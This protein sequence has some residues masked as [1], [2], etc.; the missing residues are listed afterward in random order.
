M[1]YLCEGVWGIC[2]KIYHT[3]SNYALGI[4]HFNSSCSQMDDWL[5]YAAW[6][7]KE[8]R[9]CITSTLC[10]VFWTFKI[11]FHP[12]RKWA[13]HPGAP[14]TYFNDGGGGGG[15]RKFF[16]GRRFWPFIVLFLTKT[17]VEVGMFYL[18]RRWIIKFAN[19]K[20]LRDFFGY[21]NK[22]RDFFGWTTSEVGIFW[23]IKYE[24]LSD[25]PVIKIIL[26]VGPLEFFSLIKF[27]ESWDKLKT[28]AKGTLLYA[29]KRIFQ[30][31]C[32]K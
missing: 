24:P 11:G 26:W 4:R 5:H 21:A 19:A 3:T 30:W 32:Y 23:G 2:T 8:S 1:S 14:L 25:P 17:K 31:F 9:N 28:V 6:Q 29:Q 13:L 18:S 16:L 7:M 20:T 22:T 15:V 10:C 27:L 12:T